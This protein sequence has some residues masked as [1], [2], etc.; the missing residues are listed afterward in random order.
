MPK[1]LEVL[2][3]SISKCLYPSVH[4]AYSIFLWALTS[5]LI[6][7]LFP[8]GSVQL[9]DFEGG[10]FCPVFYRQHLD[11]VLSSRVEFSNAFCGSIAA[12]LLGAVGFALLK[13]TE[14]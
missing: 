3:S 14:G 4:V 10:R 9:T 8:T 7:I 11:N 6:I 12:D 1:Y 5:A 2:M 13:S